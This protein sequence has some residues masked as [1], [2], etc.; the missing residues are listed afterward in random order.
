MRSRCSI[1][2]EYVAACAATG[3][4]LG[5]ALALKHSDGL[6]DFIAIAT[7]LA[8]LITIITVIPGLVFGILY[9]LFARLIAGP[10]QYATKGD[11]VDTEGTLIRAKV[12]EESSLSL[13]SQ[14][15]ATSARI[16]LSDPWI[17]QSR[18]M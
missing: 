12:T 2:A 8:G 9:W 10:K 4:A 13:Y 15:R 5:A 14:A 1:L 6:T 7:S 3:L 11:V 18:F 16:A 17:S